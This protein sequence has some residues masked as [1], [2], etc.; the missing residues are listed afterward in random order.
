MVVSRVRSQSESRV[1]WA[2]LVA[3]DPRLGLTSACRRNRLRRMAGAW[4]HGWGKCTR[5]RMALCS[6]CPLVPSSCRR[7][8]LGEGLKGRRPSIVSTQAHLETP[9]AVSG[10]ARLSIISAQEHL[11]TPAAVPGSA[12]LAIISTQARLE[13]PAAVSGSARLAIISTQAHLDFSRHPPPS[14]DR[15]VLRSS[16]PKPIS[17]H[18]PPSPDRRVFRSSQYHLNTRSSRDR[19][20]ELRIGG[21]HDRPTISR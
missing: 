4:G 18:P 11:K 10:S 16:Q 5:I 6:H 15:R 21:S 12:R 19:R 7:G 20:R 1:A 13:T 9:T 3:C 2:A 14:P 17:R 8:S